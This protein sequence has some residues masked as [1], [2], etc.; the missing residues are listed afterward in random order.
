MKKYLVAM[1]VSTIFLVIPVVY[2]D[3]AIPMLSAEKIIELQTQ[4]RESDVSIQRMDSDIQQTKSDKTLSEE[5][6]ADVVA[7]LQASKELAI[8]H[9]KEAKLF[10]KFNADFQALY[11]QDTAMQLQYDELYA[12]YTKKYNK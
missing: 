4:I 11:Q 12:K 3:N 6:R 1:M 7:M 2:A 9:N 8:I 5:E 10:V